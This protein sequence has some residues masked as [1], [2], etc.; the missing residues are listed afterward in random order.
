[1]PVNSDSNTLYI[2][3]LTTTGKPAVTQLSDQELFVFAN[4][5][6]AWRTAY[7]WESCWPPI[8][9]QTTA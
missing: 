8:K 7:S 5:Y 2:C 6:R 1:L 4:Q 3:T 9:N